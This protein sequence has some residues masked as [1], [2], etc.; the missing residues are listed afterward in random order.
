MSASK[1]AK[2]QYPAQ[3]TAYKV[4]VKHGHDWKLHDTCCLDISVGKE[5]H[6]GVKLEATIG[7][8]KHRFRHVAIA[9]N[10]T[11]QRFNDMFEG[12]MSEAEA[13]EKSQREGDEW[14]ARN[15]HILDQLPSYEIFRWNDWTGRADFPVKFARAQFL[16]VHNAE[17]RQNID[18][19]ID[20]IWQRRYAENPELSGRKHEFQLV[21][22]M[23]LMEETAVFAMMAE[24]RDDIHIYPGSFMEIWGNLEDETLIGLAGRKFA[25]IDFSRNKNFQETPATAALL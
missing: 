8:A 14:I 17:F 24:D 7:W 3:T 22:Y 15:R 11:L 1:V 6:E 4:K 23:Y 9:V 10:D 5:Y 12:G 13:L 20:N 19:Q 18:E 25:R 2:F 16:Y 21:S